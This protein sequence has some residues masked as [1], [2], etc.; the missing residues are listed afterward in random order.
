MAYE[1]AKCTDYTIQFELSTTWDFRQRTT[2]PYV[3]F[4]NS[5]W[6]F[7]LCCCVSIWFSLNSTF[8]GSVDISSEFSL[9]CCL[10]TLILTQ[11]EVL[12]FN[13]SSSIVVGADSN[14][15]NRPVIARWR[16]I[17]MNRTADRRHARAQSSS[18]KN[19]V[20]WKHTSPSKT[21]I[22]SKSHQ[23]EELNLK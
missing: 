1:R 22:K 16:I 21:K 20:T 6:L 19:I 12:C 5:N 23:I 8:S 15:K 2:S 13:C 11:L 10:A 9:W 14:S 3:T 7:F 18:N 4:F 17:I